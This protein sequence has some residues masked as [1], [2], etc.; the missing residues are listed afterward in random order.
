VHGGVREQADALDAEV[1]EDLAA[2]ADGAEDA[3]GAGLGAFA[4]A[5]LLM[6]D[7]A[8]GLLRCGSDG[9]L[10]LPGL[11]RAAGMV[12]ARTAA[13]SELNGAAVVWS[14]AKPRE[15]LWR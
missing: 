4:G 15:V 6:E 9:M 11:N 5:Q 12:A 7:E 13:P 2:E 1:G 10:S 8:A 3:A 14:M